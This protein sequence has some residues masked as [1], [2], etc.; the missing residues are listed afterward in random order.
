MCIELKIKSKHLALEPG[1]IRHEEKKLI[2]RMK[3]H[4]G[5]GIDY[6]EL[7]WKLNSLVNHRRNIVRHESRATHLAITY[8]KGKPYS[9]AEIKRRSDREREFVLY[10]LPRVLGMVRKYG[11][12]DQRKIELTNL[13]DWCK[14]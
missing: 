11:N 4:G 7:V 6:A 12:K 2:K 5:E 9:S 14:L 3:H 8:L 13:V 10:V 1:I